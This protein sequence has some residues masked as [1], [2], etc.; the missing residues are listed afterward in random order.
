MFHN[1][2][3]L[4]K[5]VHTKSQ[6]HIFFPISVGPLHRSAGGIGHLQQ[7]LEGRE[8]HLADLVGI[9]DRG[10]AVRNDKQKHNKGFGT[11]RTGA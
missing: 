6:L 11:N 10:K 7:T 5:V 8:E 1:T 9:F 3:V 2:R 4:S